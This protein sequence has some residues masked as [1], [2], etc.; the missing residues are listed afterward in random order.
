MATPDGKPTPLYHAAQVHNRDFA[1]IAAQ[2]QPLRS[3]A[4]YNLGMLPPGGVALPAGNPFRLDPPVP[5]RP[6]NPPRPIEGFLLGQFG[7]AAGAAQPSHA[8]VVNLDYK[9]EALTT[10][11]GPGP[12][13]TFDPATGQWSPCPDGKLRLLPGGGTLLRVAGTRK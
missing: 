13:E 1:A 10:L 12:L 8:L 7:P 11:V 3:L 2:L 6:Y 5:S 4:V 9:H